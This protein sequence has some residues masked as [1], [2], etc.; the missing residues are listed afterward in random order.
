MLTVVS[1]PFHPQL[2]GN[3]LQRIAELKGNPLIPVLVVAPSSRMVD[4]LQLALARSGKSYINLHFHTFASLAQL[5]VDAEAPL[6]KTVLSDPLFFD[7]LVKQIVRED[8]PFE[9]F[10]EMA[11]PDGFPP[12]VRGTLRDL[13]DAGIHQ[14]N[15]EALIQ[16]G[17]AGQDVDLGNLRSLLNLHRRYL[18]RI[19]ELDVVPRSELLKQAIAAAPQ[20]A[21]LGGFTEILYYGFYDLTG[22]QADFFQTVVK[23]FPSR[24]FFPYVRDNAAYAF[25]KRFRDVFVQSVMKEEIVLDPEAAEIPA[26][27]QNVSGLRDEAWYVANEAR[28]LHD[29]EGIPFYEMAVVA[30][31]K[32]RLGFVL[33]EAFADRGVPCRPASHPS[34]M[35]FPVA[36]KALESLYEHENT[37]TL[38]WKAAIE[39]A[40]ALLTDLK[41]DDALSEKMLDGLRRLGNFEKIG[42]R[43]GWASFVD[44]LRDRWALIEI[45]D[46]RTAGSGVSLLY[47]EAAR[48]LSFNTVFLIGMEEKVFPRVV[49]E[50]PFLR[51]EAR[52]ALN[53]IGHKISK[54]M[55]ALEEER[56][57]F[58]LIVGS[59]SERL[60]LL[61]QRSDDDGNVVGA[62]PYLRAFAAE[63]GSSLDKMA[64]SVPRSLLEKIKTAKPSTLGVTDVMTGFLSAR[65]E[66]D[67]L[68]VARA[69]GRDHGGLAM[70]LRLQKGVHQF[71]A[72]GGYDAMM[73]EM[74]AA[75][76]FRGGQLSASDLEMYAACGFKFFASKMLGLRP[77]DTGETESKLA[78]DV[79]GKRV[80]K[81]VEMFFRKATG[82]G[83]KALPDAVP[84]DLFDATFEEF[85]PVPSPNDAG[86]PQV[87]W[88][89]TRASLKIVLGAFLRDEFALLKTSGAS[90]A[91]FE[92]VVEGKLPPPLDA[93]KWTGKI[94]RIDL[95]G[96][97]AEVLDY[98]TG[99]PFKV[100]NVAKLAM[101]GEKLQA[102]I[103]LSLAKDF[104]E[105]VGKSAAALSFRYEFVDQPGN[106]RT[107]S[108]EEWQSQSKP[109]LTA[110]KSLVDASLA[111]NFLMNPGRQC[112]FCEVA[113]VCR[114]NHGISVYRNRQEV[115]T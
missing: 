89:A 91:F 71:D 18:Q 4:R 94:D 23:N 65:R 15:V 74:K 109:I 67:A 76:V 31:V 100:Q 40:E 55:T 77:V 78:A 106:A 97:S 113:R 35:D 102:P 64:V 83:T 84:Q 111:G 107:M 105:R 70:G 21:L 86:L 19:G 48:G 104:L 61:Y 8:K 73:G 45:R 75:E 79:R 16:E 57:L 110:L 85:F 59:A 50:D 24:F 96:D 26:S 29:E 14:D 101:K 10:E 34:L 43:V 1:G 69:L 92:T 41:T 60:Y 9:V 115:P 99:K 25:A 62:S 33:Q 17:F 7:T 56:L 58:E 39:E 12:A 42:S 80:H 87:L 22:L 3:F 30:R 37:G 90:P 49:R 20:S 47:A 66:S 54:K 88:E 103:Y 95:V 51:D 82:E 93:F 38:T 68:D 5:I 81:F 46:P 98:K 32:E 11:V 28:R 2:E 36:Q 53:G 108:A 63:R 44:T 13:L 27:I 6:K 52:E 112:D 72:P 114:R